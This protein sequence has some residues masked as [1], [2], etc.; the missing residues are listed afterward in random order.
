[1][2]R[3]VTY[4]HAGKIATFV[5]G[6]LFAAIKRDPQSK[7]SPDKDQITINKVF[8]YHMSITTHAAVWRHNR[9]PRLAKVGRLINVGPH[10]SEHM[11][12]EGRIRGALIKMPGVDRRDPRLAGQ[13]A[14]VAHDVCPG[15]ASIAGNLQ[16]AVVSSD[17]DQV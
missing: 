2:N 1:M 4:S 15:P 13:S 14:N 3:Q 12:I 6:P 11:N 17:P 9:R 16:I 7:F 10:I 5:L 8:L